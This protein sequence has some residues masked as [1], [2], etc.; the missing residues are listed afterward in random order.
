MTEHTL[1]DA[2]ALLDAGVGWA[3]LPTDALAFVL[4]DVAA[5]GRW[6]VVT[7]E[8][9]AADEL[10]QGLRL[11]HP[12]PV[13]VRS[14]PGDDGRPYDGFS[15]S[16]ELAW[17]RLRTLHQ[18]ERGR[19]VVVVSTAAA[20]LQRVPD[21][22]TR[23][24]GTLELR[25]GGTVDRDELVACLVATGYLA[26]G[27]VDQ[28]GTVSVRGDVV[29]VWPAGA[30][31]PVRVD[32]FDDEI[33]TVRPIDPA[34]QRAGAALQGVRVFPAREERLDDEA[35]DR[36]GRVLS[37]RVAAQGR[38]VV[39]RRRVLEDLRAGIRFSAL[40]DWLP[41]LVPVA[42]PLDVLGQLRLVVVRPGDVRAAVRAHAEQVRQRWGLLDDD[43]RPLV[44]PS[45]RYADAEA[46]WSVLS[47]G[48]PVHDIAPPE[49]ARDLGARR[50][51]GLAVHGTELGPVA[52]RLRSLA[53][54]GC[55]VGVVVEP[56]RAETLR[57]LLGNHGLNLPAVHRWPE[58][59]DRK[60]AAVLGSLPRGFVAEGAGWAFVSASALFGGRSRRSER[61]HA[62][63]SAAVRS[64][65]DLKDGDLVIHKRHGIGRYRGL[66]RLDMS[67]GAQ[68]FARL[69]YR[70]G[71]LM[72]LP[73]T[74]LGQISRYASSRADSRVKLDRLGGA[75]WARR[76][77][78]V[79]DAILG[80]AQELLSI[81]AHRELANRPPYPEPGELS[82]AFAAR[83]PYTETPDQAEAIVA[84]HDD[85][86]G[87]HPMDRLVCGD[88][89]FGKTEVAMRAAVRVV[90]AGRQVVVLCPTT[91]LAY[92]HLETF[93]ERLEGLPVRVEMLSRF[94][95]K[96]DE[97]Q[98]LADLRA[99]AVDVVVGT[100]RLLGRGVRYADLGLVIVDEEHRFGVRQKDRLKK[101]RAQVDFLAM[102]ATPIP[103]TLEL[104]ISGLRDL[105][106]MSTPPED[107]LAVRTLV[108]RTSRSRVRE[109]VLAELERDGQVFFVH[110]RVE[111]I[112]ATADMLREWVPEARVGVAHGQL[113][114]ETLEAVV[115]DFV[116]RHVDVLVASAIIES[117][118]DLPNVN[119]M[120]VNRADRFGLAQLYQLRGRVGRSDR[121]ATCLLLTPEDV[122]REARRRLQVVVENTQLGAGLRIA[123]ADL[124]LRGAGNLLGKAQSGN[125]E[126]VGYEVWVELLAEAVE[127]ARGHLDRRELNPEVQVPVPA[128]LPEQMIP[129]LRERLG[130]YRRLSAADHPDAVDRLLDEL[131]GW[132][133]ELP[134]PARNLGGL[135]QAGLYC[136]QL[137]I[138]RVSWLK[139]RVLLD[140]HASSRLTAERL[141]DL[142][143]RHPRRMQ[144]REGEA[145]QLEV[146]LLPSEHARP[147]HLLRWVFA[148][149]QGVLP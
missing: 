30:R 104:A 22:D 107:R 79:R 27:V 17:E 135:L 13:R 94:V 44:T 73:A 52:A 120:I 65:E 145:L 77:G 47:A 15:P 85:L 121:R 128:F 26:A 37:E 99:G 72:Y 88:V 41:A 45:D 103:R 10:L 61:A 115:V 100:T 60:V 66:V 21:L 29:D 69:E 67:G 117:G 6:L 105:S 2:R 122:T 40:Q 119:T 131:E 110:N 102:S 50:V 83:F 39:L 68:D 123:H 74:Q 24:R 53:E 20:L 118:V 89:G 143:A 82:Q 25:E 81:Y 112:D 36:L 80:V 42:D 95:D 46:T 109:A 91:V 8:Q 64:H 70:G 56:R 43:E 141:A 32:L 7:D 23:T 31:R 125:I 149:L 71:D 101:L 142:V 90:E 111:T 3:G 59:P 148:Q 33:E 96:A 137:G 78:K 127:E 16:P 98:I 116:Q 113:D 86:S 57:E 140:V 18:V 114:D 132:H 11:F 63:F 19:P 1:R 146:R 92:Q 124:E 84:L 28:P 136:R 75:T 134:E 108:A 138:Q 54:S 106:L 14:F 76:R 38:G 147:F 9:D 97:K 35:L 51:E 126:A 139:V 5:D 49:V 62:L 4:A 129:D 130:W 55:R 48:H 34:T 58:V 87:D 144:V 12:H 93:R 133:G